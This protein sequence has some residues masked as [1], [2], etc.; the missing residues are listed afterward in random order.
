MPR[1]R[2]IWMP[3]HHAYNTT[4]AEVSDTG[5]N[6]SYDGECIAPPPY[7]TL[8][9]EAEEYK[10]TYIF[11]TIRRTTEENESK[12][13]MSASASATRDEENTHKVFLLRDNHCHERATDK[14]RVRAKTIAGTGG[15]LSFASLF[16][17]L[18]GATSL[19]VQ[20]LSTASSSYDCLIVPLMFYSTLSLTNTLSAIYCICSNKCLLKIKRLR[21]KLVLE[22][23]G[24]G[25]IVDENYRDELF[26]PS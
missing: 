12:E 10:K 20:R 18:M 11:F 13:H 6:G 21:M 22:I 15:D 2:D 17:Y 23:L 5:H 9:R 24:S 14:V 8:N 25:R 3:P 1:P 7:T 26:Q 4:Y 16:R 19:K